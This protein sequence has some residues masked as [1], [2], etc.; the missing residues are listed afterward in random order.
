MVP[1]ERVKEAVQVLHER[2][3]EQQRPFVP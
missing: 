3:I 2:F 1:D